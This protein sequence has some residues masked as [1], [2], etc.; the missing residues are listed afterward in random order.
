[1]LQKFPS[2]LLFGIIIANNS[3]A[4]MLTHMETNEIREK[5]VSSAQQKMGEVGIRSVSIDDI[6]RELGMSKKTFYVYFATKDE[7]IAAI[8]EAHYEEVRAGMQNFLDTCKSM[9]AGIQ[10]FA[11]QMM[12]MPNVRQFPPFIYDLN[13]YYPALAK[14]YNARILAL[15][16]RMLQQ[17]LERCVQEGIFRKELDVEMAARML[18]RLH[19]NMVHA[20][21]E[22]VDGGVPFRKLLDFTMD[23]L[24]R[25][26][27][28]KEGVARYEELL[29]R[30]SIEKTRI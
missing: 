16:K 9:W 27:F 17:I 26:M 18:A 5:I 14:D 28:S 12:A 13:K 3:T 8:L 15:N 24:L 23:V 22:Q 29:Q 21:I 20:G 7:L 4:N 30:I 2:A 6:C 1:M 25:G 11:E 10:K 19:D